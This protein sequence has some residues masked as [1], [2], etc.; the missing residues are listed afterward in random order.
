MYKPCSVVD[1]DPYPT[2]NLCIL[3]PVP[4]WHLI[5]INWDKIALYLVL[6]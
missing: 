3:A 4:I 5:W 1:P 2:K 6:I